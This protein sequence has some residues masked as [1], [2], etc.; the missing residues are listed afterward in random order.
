MKTSSPVLLCE[1]TVDTDYPPAF[2][3]AY[4]FFPLAFDKFAEYIQSYPQWM[5]YPNKYLCLN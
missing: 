4:D 3:S 2:T 5:I 1:G